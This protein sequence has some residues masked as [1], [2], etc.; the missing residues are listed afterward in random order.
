MQSAFMFKQLTITGFQHQSVPESDKLC[1]NLA[2]SGNRRR[3]PV[4]PCQISTRL[5]EILLELSDLRL[6]G[7]DTSRIR[8]GS[9]QNGRIPGH[10]PG[11]GRSGRISGH[12]AGIL[13]RSGRSGRISNLSSRDPPRTAGSRPA[14]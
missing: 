2:M 9:S 3:I 6:S 12:L 14:S 5:A 7:W 10:L 8:P 11:S 13:D 4:V 1:W